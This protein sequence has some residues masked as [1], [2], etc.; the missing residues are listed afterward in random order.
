[1][2][3]NSLWTYDT[4]ASNAGIIA[5]NGIL[6]V[7]M[8]NAGVTEL[9]ETTGLSV[10]NFSLGTTCFY[11]HQNVDG[12]SYPSAAA[13]L[14]FFEIYGIDG[15]C[16]NGIFLV[17]GDLSNGNLVWQTATGGGQ[18]SNLYG[19]SSNSYY[20]GQVIEAQFNTNILS[21]FSSSTGT[22]LWQVEPGG[23][24]STIPTVGSSVILVG[25][26]TLSLAEGLSYSTGASRW[27]F[28]TDAPLSDTPA[29]SGDFYFGTT[30]G[31]LYAVSSAGSQVWA[32]TIGSAIETTPAVGEG[33]VFIGA[34][35]GYLHALNSTSG[36]EVW[37]DNLGSQ[38]VSSPVL[39]SNG[40]V[41]EATTGGMVEAF[42]AS[43]GNLVWSYNLQNVITA[44]PVLDNGHLF[45]VDQTGIVYA[46]GPSS[47]VTTLTKTSTNS[48]QTNQ[49][50]GTSEA[51][52]SSQSSSTTL[53]TTST[54]GGQTS[55]Q[56]TQGVTRQ[57]NSGTPA[58]L[59]NLP[60]T[61]QPNNFVGGVVIAIIGGAIVI[62]LLEIVAL[63]RWK[64]GVVT[65]VFGVIVFIIALTV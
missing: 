52:S 1:M 17:A 14:V 36:K 61:L 39:S 21:E 11:H 35:D 65:V 5:S 3:N 33:L 49:G 30:N 12:S 4:G 23:G 22:Q 20:N 15:L 40:I 6:I 60:Y 37:S 28:T 50:S 64:A 42:T 18:F 31:T 55:N 24:V 62:G 43:N 46:F 2:S 45:V 13:G 53:V 32:T 9:S 59:V 8:P 26:S 44:S 47:V 19:W 54:Q 16:S 48:V 34:D 10:V 57:G 58:F 7:G 56:L 25:F 63:D 41:Y 51:S 27:N 38:L 29:F